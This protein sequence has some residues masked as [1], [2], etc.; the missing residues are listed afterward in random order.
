[1]KRSIVFLG[2]ASTVALVAPALSYASLT[3]FDF[4]FYNIPDTISG[5]GTLYATPNGGG[6]YLAVAGSIYLRT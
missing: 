3:E 4:S 1:M 5:S 6:S 2:V